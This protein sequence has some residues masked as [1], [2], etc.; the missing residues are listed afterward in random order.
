[1]NLYLRL[2]WAVTHALLAE[3]IDHREAVHRGFRVWPHDLDVFGHM[4]NGRYLQI[5][6]VARADW[7]GRAGVLSSM[8]RHRWSAVLGGGVIRFRRSLGPF[9]QYRVRTRLLG[10]DERWWFLEHCFLDPLDQRVATGVS[11]AALRAG[12]RWIASEQVVAAVSP[13]A[14]PL[15]VPEWVHDW[16]G[17]EEAMWAHGEHV[18]PSKTAPAAAL[19]LTVER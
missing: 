2:A 3:R 19:E 17:V 1:M 11:R 8:W 9:Q 14:H 16:L 4:N 13:G 5:M 12:G 6:D 18:D 15:P 10:W 7:M